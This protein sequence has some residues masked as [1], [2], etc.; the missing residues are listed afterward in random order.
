M[1]KI[2]RTLTIA[3]LAV[4]AI[5]SCV[6]AAGCGGDK[7]DATKSD[8]NFSIVYE[9]GT[10][11]DGKAQTVYTQLCIDTNCVPLSLQSIYPDENGKLGLTQAKINEL[12]GEFVS[13]NGDV[14]QFVF[15]VVNLPGYKADCEVT[16]NGKG[17]YTVTVTKN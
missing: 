13:G 7:D 3:I 17:N 16:V 2:I 5:V 14:T 8:Y 10:A 12:L 4:V 11:V 15:H 1:K 9:D 6:L